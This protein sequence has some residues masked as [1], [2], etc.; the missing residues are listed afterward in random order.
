MYVCVYIHIFMCV[1]RVRE[2][3]RERHMYVCVC[4]YI[5]YVCI[6]VHDYCAF[7]ASHFVGP[8][9]KAGSPRFWKEIGIVNF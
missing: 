3:E 4:I 1:E 5:S 8:G 6:H 2:R 7:A 9:E